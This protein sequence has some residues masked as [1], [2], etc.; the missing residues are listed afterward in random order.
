MEHI[1]HSLLIAIVERGYTEVVMSAARAAGAKGGTVMSARGTGNF[2]IEKFLGATI[3]PEKEIVLVLTG[4]EERSAIMK[5]I[6]QEAGL[7]QEGRGL[8]F[9]L[10]VEDVLGTFT[11]NKFDD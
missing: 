9:A 11:L 1:K 6:Y 4:K 3:E 7:D 5:A 8:V 10:P 2:F